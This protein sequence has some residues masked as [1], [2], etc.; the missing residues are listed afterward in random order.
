MADCVIT[1]D[2]Q[3]VSGYNNAGTLARVTTIVD[4]NSVALIDPVA[5]PQWRYASLAQG[6]DGTPYREGFESQV[7]LFP[8]MTPELLAVLKASYEGKNTVRT[9]PGVK[10]FANYNA[11]LTVPSPSDVGYAIVS[12]IKD[13]A[14][15]RYD[16]PIFTD[17][18]VTLTRLDAL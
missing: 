10:T 15:A 9:T 11:V 2:Y 14:G 7:W 6:T 17:V 16:G 18:A 1:P 4:G 12:G 13:G 8:W 3:I 5:L